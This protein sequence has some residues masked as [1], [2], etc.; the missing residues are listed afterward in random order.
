MGYEEKF[1]SVEKALSFIRSGDVIVTGVAAAEPALFMEH[2]HTVADRV[3]HVT[4][5]N[6]LPT[7]P[8]D[9]Y[10]PKYADIFQVDNWFYAPA[11]RKAHANGNVSYIPNHLNQIATRRFQNV[12]PNIFVGTSTLPDKHG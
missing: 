1:I 6:C 10:L 7:H 12:R 5:T 9:V 11:V 2:L 8:S 4:L 3:D